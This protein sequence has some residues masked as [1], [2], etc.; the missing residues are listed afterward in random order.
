MPF[1]EACWILVDEYLFDNDRFL[2]AVADDGEVMG[3]PD[4]AKKRGE[5]IDWGGD[6][7]KRALDGGGG[8]ATRASFING[9]LD[10]DAAM[11]IVGW[12]RAIQV[13]AGV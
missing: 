10:P 8:Q 1:G 7:A 9:A 2:N 4:D 11:P 12:T 6:V 13:R 5:E 3:D